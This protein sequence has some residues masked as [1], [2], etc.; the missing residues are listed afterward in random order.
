[1]KYSKYSLIIIQKQVAKLRILFSFT[2]ENERNFQKAY[3]FDISLHYT[4][5]HNILYGQK[6]RVRAV[7][8]MTSNTQ[9]TRG[10]RRVQRAARQG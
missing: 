10:Y 2:H 9:T 1:M 3:F 5:L 4:K 8:K 7:R 6:V